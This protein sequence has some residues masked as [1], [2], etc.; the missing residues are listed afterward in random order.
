MPRDTGVHLQIFRFT[1]VDTPPAV[2]DSIRF[3]TSFE[4]N[5]GRLS[6]LSL[7]VPAEVGPRIA[8]ERIPDA[9]IWSLTVNGVPR[10]VRTG[11]DGNWIIALDPG[12]TSKVELAYLTR[13]DALTLQGR[14]EARMPGVGLPAKRVSVGIGLP[15]RLELLSIEGPVTP[16]SHPPSGPPEAFDGTPYYFSRSYYEGKGL[17]VLAYYKEPAANDLTTP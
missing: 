14:I 9:A 2:L 4:E 7:D 12:G 11:A 13:A 17:D 1:A 10:Q 15:E 8:I 3:F 6:Q 16:A 5:G